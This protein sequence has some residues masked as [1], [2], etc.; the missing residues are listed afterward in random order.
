MSYIAAVFV[1][2]T[3]LTQTLTPHLDSAS[4]LQISL[5]ITDLLTAPVHL[6][7]DPLTIHIQVLQ[8]WVVT[9]HPAH[10]GG[11]HQLPYSLP[12]GSIPLLLLPDTLKIS[13]AAACFITPANGG[14]SGQDS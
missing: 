13:A 10:I 8:A 2:A 4:F 6:H 3:S 5:A 11:H 1:T 12:V 14:D 9:C 7:S